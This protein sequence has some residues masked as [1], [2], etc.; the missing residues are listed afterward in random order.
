M[1]S[2]CA[3]FDYVSWFF[4][5]DY[6]SW[7]YCQY[8]GYNCGED[9]GCSGRCFV[10][11]TCVSCPPNT[12]SP[13]GSRNVAACSCNAGWTNI[14]VYNST[15]TCKQ[16]ETGKF[17]SMTKGTVNVLPSCIDCPAGKYAAREGATACTTCEQGKY[18]GSGAD[19]CI[20]FVAS[21][22][23]ECCTQ[24]GSEF[25]R[26]KQQ[27][28]PLSSFMPTDNRTMPAWGDSTYSRC[29]LPFSWTELIKVLSCI[30]YYRVVSALFCISY[31]LFRF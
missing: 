27:V 18:S 12:D 7:Y 6:W 28:M 10:P 31:I 19:M 9:T 13:P 29:Q 25:E 26:L 24:L 15:T 2:Y 16:C 4:S 1:K 3:C 20:T 23:S 17:K 22:T 14:N 11:S 8:Y 5:G 21:E 30:R